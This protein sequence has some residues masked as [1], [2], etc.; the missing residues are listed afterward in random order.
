[1]TIKI[2]RINVRREL[3]GLCVDIAFRSGG[4]DFQQFETV[5]LERANPTISVET[6]ADILTAVQSKLIDAGKLS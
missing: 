6:V 4:S 2:E 3:N 1:M 5:I